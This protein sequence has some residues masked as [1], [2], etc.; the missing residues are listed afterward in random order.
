MQGKSRCREQAVREPV[1]KEQSCSEQA[2]VRNKRSGNLWARN[3]HAVDKHAVNKQVKGTSGPGTCEKETI[4]QW[5]I[6]FREQAAR[7]PV[8]KEQSCSDQ[9]GVGNKRSG[10]LWARNSHAV[11]KHAGNTC[12]GLALLGTGNKCAWT[13]EQ[14]T[15]VMNPESQYFL[16]VRLLL[17]KPNSW[18]YNFVDFLG[19]LS[20][21]RF[22]Y[23]MF[24]L[25]VQTVSTHFCSGQNPL[26][27]QGADPLPLPLCV[28]K[29]GWNHLN[30]E[31]TPILP[32]GIGERCS[33][34]I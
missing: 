17:L 10:N 6:R 23:T 26:V 2:G 29:K 21:L 34:T 30:E 27:A 7:E 13:G 11:K 24:T 12:A 5:T 32:T 15:S 8:R 22:S 28:A 25:R 9:S 18:T 33:H 3:N 19:I 1:S 4:I 31:I 20:E 16:H 14:G